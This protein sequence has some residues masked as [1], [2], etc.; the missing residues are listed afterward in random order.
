MSK[1]LVSSPIQVS[2][3]VCK[4]TC[5]DSAVVSFYPHPVRH[6][7]SHRLSQQRSGPNAGVSTT[8]KV[9]HSVYKELGPSK[10]LAPRSMREDA[11]EQSER[12]CI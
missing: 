12:S 8:K 9:S 7:A 1:G 3:V 10:S 2:E 5:S 11:R 6:R 4:S